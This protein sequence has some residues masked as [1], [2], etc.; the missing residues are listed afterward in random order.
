MMAAQ[1]I[2]QVAGG[3]GAGAAG[4]IAQEAGVGPLGQIGAAL[5]GGVA[6]ATAAAPRRAPVPGL[7]LRTQEATER[8]IP[9]MTSDV[10]PPQTFMGRT[11]QQTG[12]RIP[13]A[14]T[15]PLR[16]EQQ[17]A[18]VSAVRDLLRQF[19]AEDAAGVSDNIMADLAAKRSGELQKY[20]GLKSE[21]IN[22]LDASGAVPVP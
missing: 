17:Q 3:A 1:P 4:Q 2:T 22:R 5:A 12:E 18:R 8:G 10:A 14:G 21:V 7:A 16:A 15:G 19:G 6:G 13:L 20:T 11:V 9:V